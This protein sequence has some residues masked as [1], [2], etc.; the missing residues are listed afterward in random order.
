MN[1]KYQKPLAQNLGDLAP[2]E[3]ACNFGWEVAALCSIG[4]SYT[5]CDGGGEFGGESC[6]SVGRSAS[7]CNPT[8]I[9]AIT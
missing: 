4:S 9:T 6:V 5:R 7:T 2:A 1:K 8:G 3:G